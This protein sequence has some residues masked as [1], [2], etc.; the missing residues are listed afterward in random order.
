MSYM[1][2]RRYLEEPNA[3]MSFR[4][5]RLRHIIGRRCSFKEPHALLSS[6]N[7][8]RQI[9]FNVIWYTTEVRPSMLWGLYQNAS[10]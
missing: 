2:L 5:F 1:S 7:D 10:N 9:M 3:C 8:M 6:Q 4:H